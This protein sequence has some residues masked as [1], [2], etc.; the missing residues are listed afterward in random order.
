LA[1]GNVG[2]GA[3]ACFDCADNSRGNAERGDRRPVRHWHIVDVLRCEGVL[4]TCFVRVQALFSGRYL[5][6]GCRSADR[7]SDI[8]AGDF[9]G[10]YVP[11]DN[12]LLEA[13]FCYHYPVVGGQ[14]V[15]KMVGTGFIGC[16]RIG[17][18]GSGVG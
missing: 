14:K 15:F 7:Q 3:A 9:I 12:C 18:V 2:V 1:D 6:G 5:Y 4:K 16:G 17:N 8:H 11:A 10:G 13:I